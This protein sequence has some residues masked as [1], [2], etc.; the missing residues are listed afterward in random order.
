[1]KKIFCLMVFC[2]F[3]AVNITIAQ[4]NETELELKRA[5]I[6]NSTIG[7]DN[8]RAQAGF[9]KA[10]IVKILSELKLCKENSMV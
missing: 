7:S 6:K 5:E 8:G 3:C 9:S 1:M 4:T 10:K 2:T